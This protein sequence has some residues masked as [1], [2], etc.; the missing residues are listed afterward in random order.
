MSADPMAG[1][2][3][4][5]TAPSTVTLWRQRLAGVLLV[6][7]AV[8]SIA[9]LFLPWTY[10]YWPPDRCPDCLPES[11][12][13]VDGLARVFSAPQGASPDSILWLAILVGLPLGFAVLGAR[14]LA[15][16]GTVLLR[17]KVL[18]ILAGI[19]AFCST[20]LVAVLMAY[21][22]V[23]STAAVRTEVAERAALLAPLAVLFAGI[24]MP[25]RRRAI[26]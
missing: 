17:W 25:T 26:R 10:A 7:G 23:D 1:A 15:R 11:R 13:P 24:V 8:V 9:A 3:T 22:Y 19:V 18:V 4:S 12:A 14:L 5:A 21:T 16:R 20:L 6:S 2:G